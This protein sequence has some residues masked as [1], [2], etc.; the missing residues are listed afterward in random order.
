[1]TYVFPEQARTC[2]W[3]AELP[4]V[5]FT[6]W[7]INSWK[8]IW[9]QIEKNGG[10]DIIHNHFIG[11]WQ[12]L[13]MRL[14]LPSKSHF[15]WHFHNHLTYK[16]G[17]KGKIKNY[18]NWWIYHNGW[19]IGVSDSVSDSV[20]A[21]TSKNVTTIYNAI[22]FSR[23]DIVGKDDYVNREN[24]T[25]NCMIMGNH[26]ERK[27]VD[28]A[29]KAVEYLNK[30]GQKA[31]LYVSANLKVQ[32]NLYSYLHDRLGS[33]QFE[34]FLRLIPARDDIATYYQKIDVFLSP[35]REEGWTWAI[36]EAI[37]CGDMIVTSNIPGQNENKVPGFHWIDNPNEK[38][39]SKDLA[40]Q[41]LNLYQ[42]PKDEKRKIQLKA[43]EYMKKNYS[44]EK[45]TKNVIDVYN[46]ALEQK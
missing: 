14:A 9:K 34:S 19:K 11:G 15:V 4:V 10:V 33:N 35:S 26:F 41:I 18:V 27:G 17:I 16:H 29:A 32:D 23:L 28:I 37:Y 22:D 1:M 39:V 40:N 8:R 30:S 12:A 5:Y 36:D 43:I 21:I 44:M 2:D 3:I 46:K 31:M 6:D 25:I 42:L 38:D 13:N 20:R 24:G 7:T 45:W